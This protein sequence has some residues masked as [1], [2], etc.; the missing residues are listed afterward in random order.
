M[1]NRPLRLSCIAIVLLV[2]SAW[3]S[4]QPSPPTRAGGQ[5]SAANAPAQQ[6]PDLRVTTRMVVVDVVATDNKDV[7]IKDLKA[8][9]FAV[10]EEGQEQPVRAFS[11]HQTEQGP[12]S[13]QGQTA[14]GSSPKL[15]PG[16]FSNAPRYKSNS[17]LNV[18]LLDALN[19]TLL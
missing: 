16:Y 18:L 8:D 19:S 13:A 7:P 4:A 14:A 9:D 12:A 10:Q 15:P 17:A 6:P 2:T 1:S 11:F 5:A 3:G